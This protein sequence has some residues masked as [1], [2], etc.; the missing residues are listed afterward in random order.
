MTDKLD[1]VVPSSEEGLEPLHAIYRRNTCLP[2]VENA[3]HSGEQRLISWF[4]VVKVRILSKDETRPFDP[5]GLSFMNINT[6]EELAQAEKLDGIPGTNS[7][8]LKKAGI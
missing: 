3:I 1:V 8:E 7:D 4:P 6:P 2:V 5:S